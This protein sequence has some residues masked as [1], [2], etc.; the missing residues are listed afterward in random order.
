MNEIR[1][2]VT[3]VFNYT[4]GLKGIA[5]G[6][7]NSIPEYIPAEGYLQMVETVR[8]LRGNNFRPKPYGA[9]KILIRE[10]NMAF[11]FFDEQRIGRHL[12]EIKHLRY[13]NRIFIDEMIAADDDGSKVNPPPQSKKKH[14]YT[15]KKNDF[16]SGGINTC[17]FPPTWRCLKAWK[18]KRLSAVSISAKREEARTPASNR[19]LFERVPYQGVD[20]NHNEVI[21]D[22]GKEGLN[23]RLDFRLWSG[24]EGG[25]MP[26]PSTIR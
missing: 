15:L 9:I 10:L 24:L 1:E 20:G 18:T 8:R 26:R 7:G 13:I 6:S 23:L 11:D 2:Y 22:T 19:P 5:L 21:I 17:G 3:N 25:G 12:F 4:K 14:S 16:W